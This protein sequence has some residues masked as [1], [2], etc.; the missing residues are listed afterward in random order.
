MKKVQSI[1]SNKSEKKQKKLF[2]NSQSNKN[3]SFFNSILLV[4]VYLLATFSF[5]NYHSNLDNIKLAAKEKNETVIAIVKSNDKTITTDLLF[6]SNPLLT[7]INNNF[8]LE[9]NKTLNTLIYSSL[10]KNNYD[11]VLT[12]ELAKE[13]ST[14]DNMKY[15]IS[16]KSGF[17]WS[18]GKRVT[19]DD[20]IF[21]FNQL[22]Q[23][24]QSNPYF[25]ATQGRN[26]KITK[27]DDLNFEII[28]TDS[29]AS[30]KYE[31]VFPIL[32]KHVLEKYPQAQLS[33]I[34]KTEFGKKP[35]G[36]GPFSIKEKTVNSLALTRSY[37]S[38]E[39]NTKESNYIYRKFPSIIRFNV[40]ENLKKLSQDFQL[41]NIHLTIANEDFD[42][43]QITLNNP[44]LIKDVSIS[45]QKYVLFFNSQSTFENNAVNTTL[46]LRNA[47]QNLINREKLS[48]E[49]SLETIYGPIDKFSFAYNSQI[50]EL[51][52]YSQ[53]I[54]REKLEKIG[55]IKNSE[56]K[57]VKNN[58]TLSLEVSYVE[59]YFTKIFLETF[60]KDLNTFGIE[61]KRKEIS[62]N[63]NEI[64]NNRRY[65]TLL[66]PIT[67]NSHPD[68]YE[69][70]HSS[71]IDPPGRNISYF[72][73]NL[74]DL[75]LEDS[76][77]STP[78]EIEK[79]I[80]NIKNF[81]TIFFQEVPALYLFKSKVSIL[82]NPNI[83]AD[84]SSVKNLNKVNSTE[85][86]LYEIL[87][88]E[89]N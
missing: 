51:Q 36:S 71:K 62:S 69:Q 60:E 89:E 15:L 32:P 45:N 44:N 65:N 23:L 13:I 57:Y 20:V 22:K 81:Q 29:I 14:E 58:S 49:Y 35:I 74:A 61:L 55:Y 25:G 33:D 56:N 41:G 4:C 19:T 18:D 11:D 47:M 70:W 59:D 73:Q 5:L 12:N 66:I 82:Y 72:D 48:K 63:F 64:I 42:L 27:I 86:L 50:E 30:Y 88:Q 16:M 52:Q 46:G 9:Q 28:L 21:T 17:K 84:S 80:E 39:K 37:N 26:A 1:I 83:L 38:E 67:D 87:I 3:W 34:S 7:N 43:N 85:N 6:R 75:Y 10:F 78:D 8:L 76:R 68:R 54:F 53:D 40:Y 79:Q 31:L 2:R 24:D 77:I